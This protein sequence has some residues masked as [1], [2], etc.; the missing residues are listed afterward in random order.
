VGGLEATSRA[1]A[2]SPAVNYV[3]SFWRGERPL[4]RVFW[5]DMI[6]VGSLV[7]ILATVAAMLLFV[8][9]VPIA[10]GVAVH[11]APVPYNILLFFG[12]WQSAARQPSTWSYPAQVVALLWLIAVICL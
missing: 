6:L 2:F 8:S 3:R 11:F 5:T 12:V 1:S 9:G 10:A 7:N 4:G